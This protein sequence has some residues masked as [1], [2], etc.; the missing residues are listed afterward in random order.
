[1]NV[2]TFNTSYFYLKINDPNVNEVELYSTLDFKSLIRVHDF[3]NT[4][5]LSDQNKILTKEERS[6]QKKNIKSVNMN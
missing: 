4:K 3:K 1:M 5:I 6:E 2:M